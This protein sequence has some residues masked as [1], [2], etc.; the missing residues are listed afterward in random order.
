MLPGR[1]AAKVGPGHHDIAR[2]H[3]S[4]ELRI[5]ILHAM[6]GQRFF[7]RRIQIT[8]GDDNVGI[9]IVPIAIDFMPVYLPSRFQDLR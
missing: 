7:I 2:L 6:R 9:H 5:D 3:R 4:G 8:G 1:A